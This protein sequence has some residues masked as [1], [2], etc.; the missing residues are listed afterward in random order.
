MAHSN[1]FGW[2]PHVLYGEEKK[3]LLSPFSVY[4]FALIKCYYFFFGTYT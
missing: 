3:P 4:L 2:D 1:S